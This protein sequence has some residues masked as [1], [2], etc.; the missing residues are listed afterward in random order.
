MT[1]KPHPRRTDANKEPWREQAEF[2]GE[3]EKQSPAP[4]PEKTPR[5]AVSGLKMD[6]DLLAI[7]RLDRLLAKLT[8]A[9]RGFALNFLWNKY[10]IGKVANAGSQP[11]ASS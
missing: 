5:K 9:Q 7:A 11:A 3:P 4:E 1:D 6:P 2:P 8:A 10:E